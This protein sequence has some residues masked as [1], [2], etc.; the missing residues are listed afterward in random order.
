[1]LCR[2][3]LIWRRL[4]HPNIVPFRG[5]TLSPPQII[6]EWMS[7][8]DLTT[9]INLNSDANRVALVSPPRLSRSPRNATLLSMQLVDVA[10][11]LHYLHLCDVIHGDL[12]GV[13]ALSLPILV[14][15]LINSHS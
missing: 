13:N 5:A 4:I 14:V 3:V 8:G 15:L 1:M 7:G 9:Y 6:S 2:E 12:K 11:G 10:N